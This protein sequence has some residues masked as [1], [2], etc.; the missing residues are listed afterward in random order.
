VLG[1][2]GPARGGRYAEML[3]GWPGNGGWTVSRSLAIDSYAVWA[4]LSR[5]SIGLGPFLVTVAYPWRAAVEE[6]DARAAVFDRLL[7]TLLA[8]GALLAGLGLLSEATGIGIAGTAASA[9]RV[10][11]P[12]VNPNHFA[13]W[14]GMVVPAALA[15]AVAM[16]GLVYGRLR[17]AVDDARAKGTRARQAWLWALITHRRRLWAPLLICTAVLLMGVAHAGSGS[18]GGTAALLLGLSVTSAGMARGMRR[19]G[20][21]GR[22]MRGAA[23]SL[24]L[25]AASAASVALW[26]AA[27]GTPSREFADVSLPSRLAVSVE[28]SAIVR[29]H[30]LF[31]T[32]LG[33]W[34]HAFRPYQAP[35]V[36]GGIWD[37][38][39]NDYLE[40]TAENGIVGV[41]LMMLFAL[42]VLRATRR[43]QPVRALQVRDGPHEPAAEEARSVELPEW[44]A[45][46]GQRALPPRGP[47]GR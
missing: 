43:E 35:P 19:G 34:L 9:G 47:A 36:E 20:E 46:L 14:L 13:A 22:A 39:H 33:S 38:A 21:P 25:G 29:D 1:R 27:D 31:G 16:T 12:F 15:Y 6:D 41:A 18:R 28:G 23:A 24:V 3:P 26:L 5:F 11:G 44:R 10:S 30:P 17:Q 42:V 2:L 7:L 4:E 40:A 8:A 45:A 32:G 37:H